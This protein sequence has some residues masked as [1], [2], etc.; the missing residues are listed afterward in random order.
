MI[1]ESENISFLSNFKNIRNIFD[2]NVG[3]SIG[4][5]NEHKYVVVVA[6]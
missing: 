6:T 2:A 5:D 1:I 4:L 3:I